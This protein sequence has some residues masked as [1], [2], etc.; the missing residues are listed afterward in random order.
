LPLATQLT[1]PASAATDSLASSRMVT[2]PDLAHLAAPDTTSPDVPGPLKYNGSS[3]APTVG[4]NGVGGG[5][6]GGGIGVVTGA[7]KIYLIF[8]G[9]QWGAQSTNAASDVVFANDPAGAA[10]PV[11]ELFKGIGTGNEGWSRVMTQYCEG[12]PAGS[13]SCPATAPHVGYPTSGALA[14]VWYDDR[15]AAPDAASLSQLGQEAIDAAT[16]FGNTTAAANRNAQYAILSA[17]GT[18]PDGFPT[19]GFC[20]EH[21]SS[22]TGSTVS[23]YGPLAM[24]NDPY[25]LDAGVNCGENF[26]HAGTA[27]IDDGFTIAYAHEYAETLT[28]PLPQI[29]GGGWYDAVNQEN[30]DKCAWIRSGQGAVQDVT[31]TTGTF[32]MQSTW[33]NDFGAIG[34]CEISHS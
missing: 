15:A 31:F 6:V 20:A 28:D 16:H 34:G 33:A 29:P 18:H 27:G 17:T 5:G 22:D 4:T 14:G 19:T 2:L 32:A 11:Q 8:W 26:L 23:P 12:V 3:G 24:T 25:V 10:A 9:T 13:T 7:P 30:G 1:P 21:G